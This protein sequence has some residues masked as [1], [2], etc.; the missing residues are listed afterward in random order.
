MIYALKDCLWFQK[1]GGG[2]RT[3]ITNNP[4]LRTHNAIEFDNRGETWQKSYC[5]PAQALTYP[6]S[7]FKELSADFKA[8]EQ[9]AAEFPYLQ[10][11]AEDSPCVPVHNNISNNV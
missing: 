10:H 11:I 8:S 1:L 9:W 4:F 5:D 2:R 6:H 3:S 7:F